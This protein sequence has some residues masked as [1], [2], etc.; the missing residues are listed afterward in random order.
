MSNTEKVAAIVRHPAVLSGAIDT[1]NSGGIP[2][3]VPLGYDRHQ[4]P[5]YPILGASEP[6]HQNGSGDGN[7]SSGNNGQNGSGSAGDSGSGSAGSGPSG[8]AGA[9][10]GPAGNDGNSG[11]DDGGSDEE[12]SDENNSD[13]IRDPEKKR[14]HDE[15]AKNRREAAKAKKDLEAA[16]A[17]IREFEDKDSTELDKAKRAAGESQGKVEK[18]SGTNRTLSLKLA[19]LENPKYKW[20]DVSDVIANADLSNVEIDEDGNVEGM[21]ESLK[22]LAKKKPYLLAGNESGGNGSGPSGQP[23]GSGGRGTTE[24]QRDQRVKSKFRF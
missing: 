1:L 12:D 17:R 16:N 8:T 13:D 9:G 6:P 14:L 3:L 15:A 23:I 5:I 11:A 4:K 2:K 7:G 19:I 18:L 21:E 20:H 22:A 24:E 10:S